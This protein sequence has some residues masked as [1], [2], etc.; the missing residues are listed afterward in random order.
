[1]VARPGRTLS[2]IPFF[3]RERPSLRPDL[4]MGNPPLTGFLVLEVLR[5]AANG[6]RI[7]RPPVVVFSFPHSFMRDFPHQ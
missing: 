1:M 5:L 7:P 6:K 4:P 3:D 2:P